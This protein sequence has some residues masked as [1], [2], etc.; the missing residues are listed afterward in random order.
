MRIALPRAL[1]AVASLLLVSA[2][3]G[4]KRSLPAFLGGNKGGSESGEEEPKG[5][6]TPRDDTKALPIANPPDGAWPHPRVLLSPDRLLKLKAA[7][8][9]GNPAFVRLIEGCDAAVRE[10]IEGGYEGEDWGNASADLALCALVTGKESYAKASVQYALALIDDKEKVGD[11]KGGDKIVKANDGYSIRNRGLFPALVYDWLHDHPALTAD[12]KKRILTR[13]YT[14]LKWYRADGYRNGDA[15]SNHYRGHC[16]T[17][18]AAGPAFAGDDP[19]G[20]E[21]RG[22][23]RKMWIEEVQPGFKKV[24]GGDFAEGWQYARTI[25]TSL[26]LHVDAE[27][28]APGGNPRIADELPW[29]RE[30]IVFQA[31][32]LHP[33]GGTMFDNADWNHKPA[34]PSAVPFYALSVVLP[35]A[36]SQRKA[37]FLGRL[38]L[39]PDDPLWHWLGFI[40]DDPQRPMEDPRKGAPS[41]FARG[42]GTVLARTDWGKEA[43][44]VTLTSSPFYSDHQHLDQGHFEVVR[45]KDLLVT[46]PGD[47]DS[48]STMS[49]NSL[50][51]DDS[52]ENMKKPP[53][54]AIYGTTAGVPRFEDA[55]KYVYAMASFASAY[56]NDPDDKKARSVTRAEREWL[57]SRGPLSQ[58]RTPGAARLVIYDR[59]SVRKPGYGVTWTGHAGA[60][61]KAQGGSLRI[62][63]GASSAQVTAILP[64][65]STFRILKEPTIK[66]D[67]IFMKNDPAEGVPGI[68]FETASPKGAT[69]RRFLHVVVTGTSADAF[70]PA[71]YVA[72]EGAEGARVDNEVYVFVQSAPQAA[73]SA[74]TYRAPQG[75][76]LHL[77][78]GL[79]PGGRY[80]VAAAAEGPLCKVT[81]SPGSAVTASAAGV[82][83]LAAQGCTVK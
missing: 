11:K 57:F 51:V 3:P 13:V 75:A 34:K 32:A 83:A 58:L 42:T 6:G 1:L 4:C 78:A 73:P 38:A 12:A 17:A 9:P 30:S 81:V 48:Y 70:P 39:N 7:A 26:A 33:D 68:R 53:N 50:L 61:P 24:T 44:W 40:A 21:I 65:A 19:K 59:V 52:G 76:T 31:H 15:I 55:Q 45:G 36:D 16:A 18:A 71:E 27:S 74:V 2:E 79:A 60:Q 8:R 64:K 49:H 72:G 80:A 43:S 54:Q 77:V 56:D 63:V 20:A 62:D 82:L 47:Y 25:A 35:D 23:A 22:I 66:T 46:D 29:L 67:D 10:K 28:R 69:E 37:L 14:Y 5:S 41:H